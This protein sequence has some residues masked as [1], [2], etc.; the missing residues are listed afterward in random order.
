MTL[1]PGQRLVIDA[2]VAIKWVVS[3]PHSGRAE[4]LLDHGPVA[5]DL[6]WK[7]VRRPLRMAAR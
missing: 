7:K 1:R 4:M 5:T 6:I 3:E 2:N